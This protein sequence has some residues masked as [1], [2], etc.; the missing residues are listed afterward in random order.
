MNL[1]GTPWHT[2]ILGGD[3]KVVFKPLPALDCRR[4]LEGERLTTSSGISQI[5]VCLVLSR[6]MITDEACPQTIDGEPLDCTTNRVDVVAG[7]DR[8]GDAHA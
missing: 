8:A 6:Q 5:R 4:G 2:P 1:P 7:G 3:H